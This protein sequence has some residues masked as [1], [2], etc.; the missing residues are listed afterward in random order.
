ML[1][2]PAF[3]HGAS[4]PPAGLGGLPPEP[5]DP[6]P[7][8]ARD[9]LL[10]EPAL[11]SAEW[12]AGS[13]SLDR[14]ADEPL[15]A[16]QAAAPAR[17]TAWKGAVLASCL[18]HAAVALAF[19]TGMIETV[20]IAGSDQAGVMLLGNAP[21]DQSSAGDGMEATN[22]TLVTM[23]DPKPVATVSAEAVGET[24]RVEAVEDAFGVIE[25]GRAHV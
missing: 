1:A 13:A 15:Q 10:V 5:D 12:R 21:D 24:D 11:P 19:L 8:F 4:W 22:V 6:R 16:A 2:E 17:R 18:L 23:L 14:P 25:I 20:E 7:A 9:T 3:S